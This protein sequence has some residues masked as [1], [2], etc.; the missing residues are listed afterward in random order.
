MQ[1]PAEPTFH[2]DSNLYPIGFKAEYRDSEAGTVFENSVMDGMD[3]FS[4]D[5]PAFQ[6]KVLGESAATFVDKRPH[7][8][9]KQV[10]S[11]PAAYS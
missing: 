9:W 2:D 4:E 8:V 3:V 10:G 5:V 11:M 1:G 7:S 6:V